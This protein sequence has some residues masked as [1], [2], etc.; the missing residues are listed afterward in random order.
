MKKGLFL[1]S[2]VGLLALGITGQA[3]TLDKEEVTVIIHGQKTSPTTSTT[4]PTPRP[5]TSQQAPKTSSEKSNSV[6][7]ITEPDSAPKAPLPLGAEI[8]N[9]EQPAALPSTDLP[10]LPQEI[11]ATTETDPTNDQWD[12]PVTKNTP[13]SKD[14]H[15]KELGAFPKGTPTIIQPD[16]LPR[17]HGG[18][19]C[20][21]LGSLMGTLSTSIN[22]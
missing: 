15:Q 3:V 18:M 6:Q 8:E 16:E 1:I 20:S 21:Y 2:T 4:V 13:S 22:R 10:P 17:G 7:K 11:V 9:I 5:D 14:D 12:K 19:T